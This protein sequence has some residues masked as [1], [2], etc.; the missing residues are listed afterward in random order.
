MFGIL[1]QGIYRCKSFSRTAVLFQIL[2]GARRRHIPVRLLPALVAQRRKRGQCLLGKTGF[3][4]EHRRL[5]PYPGGL[6]NDGRLFEGGCSLF[7]LPG[8]LMEG[9]QELPGLGEA[10]I[11][12]DRFSQVTHGRMAVSGPVEKITRI[13]VRIGMGFPCVR[14]KVVFNDCGSVF[15]IAG[16]GSP[17]RLGDHPMKG[18]GHGLGVPGTAGRFGAFHPHPWHQHARHGGNEDNPKLTHCLP[19]QIGWSS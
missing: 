8:L 13:I 6:C 10:G 4:P 15:K 1:G 5:I 9:S 17:F 18:F 12:F 2:M 19:V 7:E 3:Q 16:P 11:Q 14:F